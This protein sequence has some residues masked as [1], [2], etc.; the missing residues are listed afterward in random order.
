MHTHTIAKLGRLQHL[1]CDRKFE[2]THTECVF[3]Y[4]GFFFVPL[5][6]ILPQLLNNI[7]N[8]ALQLIHRCLHNLLHAVVTDKIEVVHSIGHNNKSNLNLS[9]FLETRTK[10]IPE[11]PRK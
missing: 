1:A 5:L 10:S 7:V 8:T 4:L 2:A 9:F 3:L 11:S 6:S